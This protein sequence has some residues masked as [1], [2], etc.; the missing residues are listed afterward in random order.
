MKKKLII[1]IACATL[2]LIVLPGVMKV[3]PRDFSFIMSVLLFYTI[4]PVFSLV[5]GIFAGCDTKSCWWVCLA[6]GAIFILGSWVFIAP[7]NTDFIV[8]SIFYILVASVAMIFTHAIRIRWQL[9]EKR[10]RENKR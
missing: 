6:V 10:K 7:I 1:W 2:I 9:R 4:N 5:S 3:L 8:Y